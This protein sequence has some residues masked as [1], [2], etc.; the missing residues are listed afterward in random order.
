MLL[1][2]GG[3][4]VILQQRQPLAEISEEKNRSEVTPKENGEAAKPVEKEKPTEE[5]KVE[6]PTEEKQL[7]PAEEREKLKAIGLSEKELKELGLGPDVATE[8]STEVQPEE[9]CK[10]CK[11]NP[12]KNCKECG[13]Q[14]C[15]GKT[16]EDELLFCEVLTYF[17]FWKCTLFFIRNLIVCTILIF[18]HFIFLLK[19]QECEFVTHF[20]CLPEPITSLDELPGG[21]DADFYCPYCKNDESDI[22]GAGKLKSIFFD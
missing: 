11:S 1:Q 19:L 15:G 22:I 4:T 9:P 21:K 13:C 5:E 18:L 12:E 6:E 10:K 8:T 14:E 3:Y 2:E 16:P 7:S 20:Q 17:T